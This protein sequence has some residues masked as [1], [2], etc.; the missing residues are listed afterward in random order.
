MRVQQ[1]TDVSV[2]VTEPELFDLTARINES[3]RIL[4]R[5]ARQ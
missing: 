4:D 2:D 5:V 3:Q 1:Q